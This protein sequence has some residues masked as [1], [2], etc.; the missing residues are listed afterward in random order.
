M[1]ENGARYYYVDTDDLGVLCVDQ[2][3]DHPADEDVAAELAVKYTRTR[4]TSASF[5]PEASRMGKSTHSFGLL[6]E[7]CRE[8]LVLD[9]CCRDQ[10]HGYTFMRPSEYAAR[11]WPNHPCFSS[12][13]GSSDV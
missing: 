12:G 1:T 6:C 9:D 7:V 11:T 10:D 2:L 4:S 3:S 5:R 13:L 8:V